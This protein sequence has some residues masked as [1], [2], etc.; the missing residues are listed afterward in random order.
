MQTNIHTAI[1][2]KRKKMIK[3]ILSAFLVLVVLLV[4]FSFLVSYKLTHLTQ[5]T[6][7]F[8]SLDYPYEKVSF[9]SSEGDRT[10]KGVF[11]PA[12]NSNQTLV[13]VHG[14]GSNRWVKGRTEKL[15]AHFIP[16]GYNIIAFD[17]SGQGESDGKMVTLGYNEQ[18]DLEGAL[19]Y[20]KERGQAGE[21]I[22]V[23]GFSMGGA[24]SL[25][26]ASHDDRIDAVIADSAFSNANLFLSEG[27]SYFTHLPS[28]PFNQLIIGVVK[29][30]YGVPLEPLSPI[31]DLKK[32]KSK[33]VFLIHTKAD[34][35]IPYENSVQL[36]N[37]LKS[38]PNAKLW[39]PQKGDHMDAIN[40]YTDEYMNNVSS[41]LKE[42]LK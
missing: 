16:E 36:Y 33:P 6:D 2:P 23:L 38:N 10:I 29:Y 21:K 22:A 5:N 42:S 35:Q 30:A 37:S 24:T 27:L 15:V 18:K 25:M 7:S 9:K 39:T 11:F 34:L 13:V 20:L 17:L 1:M 28:F 12:N 31:D 32:V 26:V 40:E 41:F 14:Y 4:G 8:Y 3:W 19:S